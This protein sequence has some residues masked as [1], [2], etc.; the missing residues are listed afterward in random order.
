MASRSKSDKYWLANN[1]NGQVTDAQVVAL[2]SLSNTELDDL[3]DMVAELKTLTAAMPV[4][5]TL[6]DITAT[7]SSGSAPAAGG[8]LTIADAST[9]TV[10]EL[11]DYCEELR[12]LLA[13]VIANLKTAGVLS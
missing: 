2:K 12:S 5:Q 13:S 6:E 9:P 10:V 8:S 11:L 3:D 1:P 7:Y 4:A